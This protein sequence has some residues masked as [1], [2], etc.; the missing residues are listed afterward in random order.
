MIAASHMILALVLLGVVVLQTGQYYTE[1]MAEE[2][3]AEEAAQKKEKNAAKKA[4]K[5]AAKG[6]D[7]VEKTE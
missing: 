3:E 5:A 7:K 2:D 1:R 4:R 6:K